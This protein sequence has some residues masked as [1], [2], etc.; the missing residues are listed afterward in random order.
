MLQKISNILFKAQRIF[1]I[2][3][4]VAMTLILSAHVIMRFVF[5]SPIIWTDEVV[6]MVQGVL[7]F[8]G[9]GYCFH[10]KQ[11]VELEVVYSR[12]SY[13]VKC[14]FDIVSNSVMLFCVGYMVVYS[15]DFAI[16]KNIP[17]NTIPWMQQSWIYIFMVIGFVLAGAYILVQLIT[18]FFNMYK[19]I[20]TKKE[21]TLK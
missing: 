9:I 14:L 5:R 4:M 17:M 18:V 6:T 8:A 7:A 21:D 10:K 13:P 11:H 3:V 2:T 19:T 20:K 16:Y 12:V 1:F 15:L